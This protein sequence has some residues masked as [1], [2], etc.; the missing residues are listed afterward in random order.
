VSNDPAAL[1]GWT[2]T[3]DA[4]TQAVILASGLDESRV[5]WAHLNK[6]APKDA[7]IDMSLAGSENPGQD[8]VA[9][10]TDLARPPGKEV[11]IEVY[12]FRETNLQI[13]VFTDA[14]VTDDDLGLDAHALAEKMRSAFSLPSVNDRAL[15]AGVS[16]FDISGPIS[17]QPTIVRAGFRGRAIWN[18]RCFIPAI[19]A[20][21]YTTYIEHVRGTVTARNGVVDAERPFTVP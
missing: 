9:T 12:G 18:V 10:T 20:W 19:A 13:E 11:K 2:K 3:Q 21:E 15:D 4:I 8:G 7:Y 1:D 6:N 17:Y 5:I 16:F 14:V